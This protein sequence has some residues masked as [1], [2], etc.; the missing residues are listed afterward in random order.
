MT[1]NL[2]PSAR[3]DVKTSNASPLRVLNLSPN[4]AAAAP[5]VA[6]S[7]AGAEPSTAIADAAPPAKAAKPNPPTW[8]NTSKTRAPLERRE[9]NSWFGR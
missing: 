7:S 8:L 5:C 9:T 1:S 3:K 6:R 2:A 4:P